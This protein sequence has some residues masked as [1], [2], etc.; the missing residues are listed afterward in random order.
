MLMSYLLSA[1]SSHAIA[2]SIETVH[3]WEVLCRR[4]NSNAHN[5]VGRYLVVPLSGLPARMAKSNHRSKVLASYQGVSSDDLNRDHEE[6]AYIANHTFFPLKVPQRS[7][8]SRVNDRA[9]CSIVC[10]F[11]EQYRECAEVDRTLWDPMIRMLENLRRIE[12]CEVLPAEDI[13]HQITCMHIGDSVVFYVRAQNAAVVVRKFAEEFVFESFE[14]AP[15]TADVMKATG[16]LLCSYPGPAIAV[17]NDIVEDVHFLKEL[18]SFLAQMSVD[19]LDSA[20]TT[21]KAGSTV[22]EKRDSASP[23][24]ITQLLTGILRGVGRPADVDRVSKRINDDILWKDAYLPWRRSPLWL[25]IRVALQTSLGRANAL[26][27]YKLF[28]VFFMS[29]LLRLTVQEEFAS[30]HLYCFRA[31]LSR[32]LY[33]LGSSAPLFITQEVKEAVDETE[34]LLQQRW[35]KIQEQQAVSPPWSPSTLDVQSDTRLT[36]HHSRDYISKRLTTKSTAS[37]A[38][39]FEPNHTRRLRD[40]HCCDFRTFDEGVLS[41]AFAADGDIYVALADFEMLVQN[42]VDNWVAEC[43]HDEWACVKLAKCIERYSEAAPKAYDRNPEDQSIALLTIFELW[44]ALDKLAVNQCPLLQDY[45][46]EVP[47]TLFQPLL[48]RKRVLLDRLSR[49][50]G[51]LDRRR[52]RARGGWSVFNDKMDANSLAVRFFSESPGL[53]TLKERIQLDAKAERAKKCAELQQSNNQH[54]DLIAQAALHPHVYMVTRKGKRI[55]VGGHKCENCSL[56][57]QAKR[58]KIVPHEWPLPEDEY[59]AQATVFELECPVSFGAWRAATYHILHDVCQNKTPQH[60]SPPLILKKYTALMKYVKFEQRFTRISFASTTKSFLQAHYKTVSIPATSTSVCVKNGLTYRLY[61]SQGDEWAAN[62]LQN[63]SKVVQH[64]TFSLSGTSRYRTMQYAIQ[65]TKH[66]PNEVL[67]CQSECPAD[68]DLHEYTAFGLLRSGA[69]LQWL[70]I[71]RSIHA[72]ELSFDREEVHLLLVQAIW[73]V[74]PWCDAIRTS[75]VEPSD[76][77]FGLLLLTELRDLLSSIEG[78]WSNA[79]S[80]KSVIMLSCR[81]LPSTMDQDVRESA[82]GLLRDARRITFR[83]LHELSE[84]LSKAVRED[85]IFSLQLRICAMAAICRSTYDA[86]LDD[87]EALLA[88]EEDVSVLIQCA[89]HLHDNIP[90]EKDI[91]SD[92]SLLLA[93]DRRLSHFLEPALIRRVSGV[94]DKP[95]ATLWQEFQEGQT[96][97]Q[98]QEPNDRWMTVAYDHTTVHINV[99]NGELLVGGK[100]VGRLP[101]AIVTHPDYTRIFSKKIL[102]VIPSDM[103]GMAFAT[104]ADVFGFHVHFALDPQCGQLTIKARSDSTVYEVIPHSKFVGDLPTPLIIDYVHWLKIDTDPKRAE[105]ELRPLGDLWTPSLDNWRIQ[106]SMNGHSTMCRKDTWLVDNCSPSLAMV[107]E[108]LRPLECA[109]HLIITLSAG[110]CLLVDLPRFELSFVVEDGEL[111]SRNWRGLIVDSNQ[112]SKTMLGLSSQLVLTQRA[113][114]S[115]LPP[116]RHV[117]IPI[118]DIKFYSS[119]HHVKVE[120]ETGTTSRTRYHKYRIDSNLGYLVGNGTLLSKLY[121]VY[122]HA[123]TSHCLPDPLTGRTGIEEALS[124]FRSARCLSFQKLGPDEVTLL[125]QIGALTPERQFYPAHLRVM[126]T[127]HWSDLSPISQRTD[128]WDCTVSILKHAQDL[129]NI[130]YP[131]KD[132]TSLLLDALQKQTSDRHLQ[133]RAAARSNTIYGHEYSTWATTDGDD[134]PYTTRDLPQD[135]CSEQEV[136]AVSA[137][138]H[139]WPT[140]LP[141]IT[142]LL[143]VMVSWQQP[144]SAAEDIAMSYRRDWLSPVL[145]AIWLSVYE[146]CRTSSAG[147]QSKLL[148]ILSAMSYKLNASHRMQLIGTILAFATTPQFRSLQL[149]TMRSGSYNL[150]DGFTPRE[151]ELH[152]L[153]ITFTVPYDP[154]TFFLALSRGALETED[155]FAERRRSHHDKF[156]ASKARELVGCLIRQWPCHTPSTPSG[157]SNVI[158]ITKL[159]FSANL[160]FRSWYQNRELQNHLTQVQH[161][162]HQVRELDAHPKV[163]RYVVHPSLRTTTAPK[164]FIDAAGL[165]KRK[166]PAL[167]VLDHD[168]EVYQGETFYRLSAGSFRTEELGLLIR[169]FE[170]HH[171][172]T[173][174]QHYGHHLECSRAILE[175]QEGSTVPYFPP[176]TFKYFQHYRDLCHQA[177]NQ[178]TATIQRSLGPRNLIE[179]LF[180]TSG[181]WPRLSEKSLLRNLASTSQTRRMLSKEWEQCL[182]S[183]ARTCLQF[184]RSQRLIEYLQQKRYEDL[185]KE[186]D[187]QESRIDPD[188]SSSLL[189]AD[190][191]LVQI[192][193]NF[194][195]RPLQRHVAREMI[196]PSSGRN[197]V[198]QLNMGEGKSAVIAPLVATALADG[199]KLTRVV[200][201]KSLASQMFHLLVDR[202]SGLANRRIF[203]LPFSRDVRMAPQVVERIRSL[204]EDCI[205]ERGILVAQ[206]EHI[207]SFKL[208][209]IDHSGDSVSQDGQV[210]KALL[211]SQRWLDTVARDILDESDEMLNVGYQLVY[212]AGQQRPVEDHPDRWKTT[213][214]VLSLIKD[215]SSHVHRR[216]PDEMEFVPGPSGTY[217]MIRILRDHAWEELA[218]GVA[219]HI[220]NTDPILRHLPENVREATLMFITENASSVPGSGVRLLEQHCKGDGLWKKLLL[221]RGLLGYGLIGYVLKEKRWR[222]DYGLDLT[223]TLLAVPYRAKDVPSL[224][225]DFGHP[226]VAIVLTCLSYYYGGLT[227]E[228]LNTCFELLFRSDEREVLYESWVRCNEAVPP[229]LQQL[230]GVN[231]EDSYQWE[232]FLIPLFRQCHAVIDFYLAEVVFPR[233][234]KEFPEKLS[235]SA[236]DLAETRTHVTTGFSGTNDNQDLLPSSITQ[237][238][239]VDQLSTNA[240]VLAYL[241]QPENKTYICV[242]GESASSRNYLDL[243]V[244]QDSEVRVLLDVGAQMLDMENAELAKHWLSLTPHVAAAIF[245]DE[246]DELMVLTRSGTIEAFVSSPYS[247]QLDQCNVYLDDAHTRGTDLKLPPKARAAV[248]LGPKVTK[249]RL[250]QGCMRMRKLG[251]GQSVLFLA[252]PEVDRAIRELSGPKDAVETIDILR[253]AMVQTCTY[254]EHHVSHW[255]HQGIGYKKRRAAWNQFKAH[256]SASPCGSIQLATSRMPSLRS[257]WLSPEA[258]PLEEMYG[259]S[260]G[261]SNAL[262]INDA[263][264]DDPELRDRFQLFGVTSLLD[265]RMDEE[266]EREVSQELEQE[267]EVER[268]LA[269]KPATHLVHSDVKNFVRTGT[270]RLGPAFVPLFSPLNSLPGYPGQ[271]VWSDR[272]LATKDFATTVVRQKKSLHHLSDCMAPVNWIVSNTSQ[273]HLVVFSAFEVNILLPMIRQSTVVC[274]HMYSPRVTQS[275]K[276]LDALNFYCIPALRKSWQPKPMDICQLNLW[277]GQLYFTNHEMYLQLCVYLGICAEEPPE[278]ARVQVDGFIEPQDRIEPMKS[279]CPFSKS[280]IPLVKELIGLRRKGMG[281]RSTHMGKVLRSGFLTSKYF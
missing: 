113:S 57:N 161:V 235:T 155:E 21:R 95:V 249:D 178:S 11:A 179:Q 4:R 52:K 138:V 74:G 104:R 239:P 17:P 147:I 90:T 93:R 265:P 156:C 63:S 145:P 226:D 88:S 139:S 122:L 251:N 227:S 221:L 83:W 242:G 111:M 200:V 173:F 26:S 36:L 118:G 117:V 44:V 169:E 168:A 77:D 231:Y 16:K 211:E 180:C 188:D 197:T 129:V 105:I 184:Q 172:S 223:R 225:A 94:L 99:L 205:R 22:V 268:P 222:V 146:Q 142:D 246:Q 182:V 125:T 43:L 151:A 144:V 48:L 216:Y 92:L 35:Q 247:Q 120:V 115:S 148:F 207:L 49:I 185:L 55:H 131:E 27:E 133:N 13:Q 162:L 54:R 64:C 97:V 102:D 177:F 208:M 206:P 218:I 281:Y 128:F 276:P 135:C 50:E 190:W 272:I 5:R 199:H 267:R 85:E 109:E 176:D 166:A 38:C 75:H 47:H 126:Q 86:D 152:A 69:L 67:A 66:C 96:W 158:N 278:G 165:F 170:H 106:F 73:Q 174:K 68:L 45:S 121:Q 82:Y 232:H 30:D 61:D 250:L 127:V 193:N 9:M 260:A 29:R 263:M 72:R 261:I 143:K 130:F 217:P 41:T 71:L 6:L 123:L 201:L 37:A 2:D 80:A 269:A 181:Q 81:L 167:D 253:W 240:R 228:Q 40:T 20:A 112:S 244:K 259:F 14:V 198:L 236:W 62:Y 140:R 150:A 245:F 108:R 153:A 160:K 28:M 255:A 59:A 229:F 39:S 154:L 195:M 164:C 91:P 51:Y 192:E 15:S 25:V 46:P 12:T 34:S 42:R 89:V 186:L 254:I 204:Y 230:I 257:A 76:R 279:L 171:S 7:D 266:Q 134:L 280:P 203:Y 273:S 101:G 189:N 219:K 24:Y 241:L 124:E 70:N 149:P 31:K 194:L 175:A 220:V 3:T 202:L 163:P 116:E 23:R 159:M 8:Q 264:F 262:S 270:V 274:L 196:A 243:L 60:A 18:S 252:P 65:D 271:H 58:M 237:H 32:R 141:T 233:D 19:E 78:N 87:L 1:A 100:P 191:L 114:T 234:A 210:T 56:T 238:D 214:H 256:S 209:G 103:P 224:R 258:R 137:L 213:Q 53:Q 215:H 84:N 107:S 110:N 119:G 212:T 10:R 157:Y 248:T 33:K 275:M 187:N 79:T 277:A 136:A 132:M 183:Y 98:L